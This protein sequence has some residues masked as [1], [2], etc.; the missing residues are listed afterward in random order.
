MGLFF[1]DDVMIRPSTSL[2]LTSLV[3]TAGC[4][5]SGKRRTA[6]RLRNTHQFTLGACPWLEKAGK[7]PLVGHDI[8]T[9]RYTACSR[10]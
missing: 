10:R 2:T 1:K 6:T 5:E 3:T 4:A 7:G 9:R 8:T